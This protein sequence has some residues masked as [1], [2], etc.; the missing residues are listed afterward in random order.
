M[1]HN[2]LWFFF[3]DPVGALLCAKVD[4]DCNYIC[5][6]ILTWGL[7]S[8]TSGAVKCEGSE[9]FVV[10]FYKPSSVTRLENIWCNLCKKKG[11][12]C[13]FVL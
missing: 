2:H 6:E 11:G 10:S 12:S 9:F 13:E 8:W 1:T 3:L 5:P 4:H 7:C